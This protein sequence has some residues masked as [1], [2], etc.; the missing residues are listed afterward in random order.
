[1]DDLAIWLAPLAI[2]AAL[3]TL[4]VVRIWG[5]LSPKK[6]RAYQSLRC[7]RVE[8]GRYFTVTCERGHVIE[9]TG[10]D[11][12]CHLN[13]VGERLQCPECVSWVKVGSIIV[14]RE[15]NHEARNKQ[16]QDY[17]DWLDER[18]GRPYYVG[19]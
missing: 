10:F 8:M 18:Y 19:A 14:G 13:S 5:I 3:L 17:E 1:M 9:M 11:L 4:V 2:L 7:Q 12:C 16:L 15:M 6:V